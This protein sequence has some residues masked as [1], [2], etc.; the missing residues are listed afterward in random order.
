MWSK[1][2]VPKNHF[3]LVGY[4]GYCVQG[5]YFF[6]EYSVSLFHESNCGH[7]FFIEWIR[8]FSG[9][10]LQPWIAYIQFIW[11]RSF[12]QGPCIYLITL[13]LVIHYNKRSMID[14]KKFE[15]LFIRAK[16]VC[17][18]H[19]TG[20]GYFCLKSTV[21]KAHYRVWDNLWQLRVF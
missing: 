20:C 6:S 3:F 8:Y 16:S 10:H 13:F 15:V 4:Y 9:E 14:S 5:I 19:R 17:L 7:P 12:C 1:A 21:L 2:V 18:F 11:Q